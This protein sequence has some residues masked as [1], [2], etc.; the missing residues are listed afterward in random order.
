MRKGVQRRGGR[1]LERLA[2]IKTLTR[3]WD[4]LE[5]GSVRAFGVL[6]RHRQ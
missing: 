4:S 1:R 3:D 2:V 5:G 6:V